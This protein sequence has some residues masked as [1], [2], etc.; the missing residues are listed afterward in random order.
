MKKIISAALVGIFSLSLLNAKEDIKISEKTVN[1]AKISVIAEKGSK[2]IVVLRSGKDKF[3]AKELSKDAT[4]FNEN[5]SL[6]KSK[7][8]SDST[9]VLFSGDGKERYSMELSDLSASKKY[10]IEVYN[11]KNIEKPYSKEFATLAIEPKKQSGNIGFLDVDDSNISLLWANGDGKGRIVIAKK[12]EKITLPQD[13]VE[14]IAN[15][16]FGEGSEI[17]DGTFVVFDGKSK[18]QNRCKVSKLSPGKYNFQVIEYNGEGESRNYLTKDGK[19]NPREKA[20]SIPA[21]KVKSAEGIN[22]SGFMACWAKVEGATSYELD[23]AKNE[24]FTE[25]VPTFEAADVGDLDKMELGDLTKGVYYYRLRA[26]APD[27]KSAN[28][29]IIKVEIK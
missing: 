28:S 10:T 26:I 6:V 16:N 22:E 27:G 21:P 5:I 29:K 24:S 18:E 13:G 23:V 1:T 2:I 19:S 9:Y 14:Y 8:I 25:F 17:S 20:T 12:G 4:D 3:D 15:G 7:K 11:L